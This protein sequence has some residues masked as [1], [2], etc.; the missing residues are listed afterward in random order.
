[1]HAL[2]MSK[3]KQHLGKIAQVF[4]SNEIQNVGGRAL[5]VENLNFKGTCS[6]SLTLK[7]SFVIYYI[8]SLIF[9]V[10]FKVSKL[11]AWKI[12]GDKVRT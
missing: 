1:M 2:S 7:P 5:Q 6:H 4:C 8:S 10:R 9:C 3:I 12:E 11:V